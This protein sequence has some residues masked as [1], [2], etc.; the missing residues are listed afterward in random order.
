MSV[1]A[2]TSSNLPQTE[3]ES[4]FTVMLFFFALDV[5]LFVGN[6]T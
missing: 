2:K 4:H 6:D 5:F 1:L 3:T